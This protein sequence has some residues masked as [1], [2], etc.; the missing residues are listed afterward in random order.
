M[1]NLFR[2]P[3]QALHGGCNNSHEG[4]HFAT[5]IIPLPSFHGCYG[6]IKTKVSFQET[7]CKCSIALAMCSC[8]F[9]REA[10]SSLIFL[11]FPLGNARIVVFYAIL[12]R[13]HLQFFSFIIRGGVGGNCLSPSGDMQLLFTWESNKIDC[14]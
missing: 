7:I 2:A 4:V 9:N 1:K 6:A 14:F 13:C 10:Q 3:R 5:T 8:S 11:F 12:Q